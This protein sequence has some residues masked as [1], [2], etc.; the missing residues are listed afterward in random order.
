FAQGLARDLWQGPQST[1]DLLA[2]ALVE[3]AAVLLLT[4]LFP[5]SHASRRLVTPLAV[6]LVV[7]MIAH[8]ALIVF[9]NLVARS[10][11]RHHALA[12]S[13]IRRGA[14]ARVF[15]T[16]AIAAAGASV[17][18]GAVLTGVPTALALAAVLALA[19]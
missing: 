2:Q 12:V 18:L 10:P 16:G 8:V 3:G 6:T 9:E 19:A 11:T 1:I 15:W 14:F 7:A 17:V 5:G 13:A 4:A